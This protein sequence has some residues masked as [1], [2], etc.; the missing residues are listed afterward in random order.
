[1]LI[2]LAISV[3]IS[4]PLSRNIIRIIFV[5][6][7]VR[8]FI[9]KDKVMELA[10]RY[11]I[12]L[13]PI[14]AFA[15][16]M[17]ISSVYGGHLVSDSDS[18][19]YWFFFIHNTIL[20]VPM[21]IMMRHKKIS[22]KLLIVTGISLLFDD[23]FVAWQLL[24]GVTYPITFLNDSP[25]Q[26]SILYVIL[27]PTLLILLLNEEGDLLKK[28]FYGATFFISL[29]AFLFLYTSFAQIV[30]TIIFVLILFESFRRCKKIF[31]VLM[32]AGIFIVMF[33]GI[34][35]DLGDFKKICAEDA[36]TAR[37]IIW[38]SSVDI[39]KNQPF[40]GVGLGNYN[41]VIN[42]KYLAEMPKIKVQHAYNTYLQFWA[43]TGIV[44]LILFCVIFGGILIWARR[45]CG[46]LYG[47]IL[48][49]STLS[50]IL[51]AFSDFVFERYSALR[52]YWFLF[53]VCVA[54]L[55]R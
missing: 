17:I 8:F 6:F 15:W 14:S 2:L 25:F 5:M 48:F 3:C 36:F 49:Y 13:L 16:W 51:Y 53:G 46:N 32:I 22:E 1:M 11:K 39:I 18:N 37:N 45:R 52:L 33:Q 9:V 19:V 21:I 35:K 23:F 28:I 20:L 29:A 7:A 4:E 24:N 41:K 43:E 47:R 26:S 40:M 27:L 34:L 30:V 12:F 38:E 50:L 54:S 44:G 42:E 55:D 10:K 31:L